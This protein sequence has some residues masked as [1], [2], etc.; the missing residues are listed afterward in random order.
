[1]KTIH[2]TKKIAVIATT[3]TTNRKI[4]R[5]GRASQVWIIDRSTRCG[6]SRQSG[7]DAK[8]VCKGCPLASNKGCY[9][10]ART[11]TGVQKAYW[12]GN[13][14]S[15]KSSDYSALFS[16]RY[17]RLGAYG[18]PSLLPLHKLEKVVKTA[19]SWTG[20]FHDW[21]L[22]RPERARKYGRFLMASCEPSNADKA[23]KLGLR[24][25]TTRKA[26]DQ[27]PPDELWCPSDRGVTCD[28]CRLC[29]GTS[30]AGAK[31]IAIA[32]HGYQEKSAL[33]A[34]GNA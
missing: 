4:S 2:E 23:K 7:R 17:V 21:H 11:V 8:T 24:T 26:G 13:R 1:M 18:N 9:V 31:N 19:K 22:M 28:Q 32:V 14:P 34:T 12:A 10:N 6:D 16:G 29:A 25:F 5:D 30:K 15:A 27:L 20:Y 33:K 3:G